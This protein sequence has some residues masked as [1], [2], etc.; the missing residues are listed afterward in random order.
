MIRSGRGRGAVVVLACVLGA[1]AGACGRSDDAE[2]AG[3][4]FS[5]SLAEDERPAVREVL[6]RFRAESG[7]AVAL[8]A[9]TANDLPE[10]LKVE[11]GSGRP[12]I[13]LFA[14][15]NLA[16]RALVDGGLVQALDDVAVPD[17][18]LPAMAPP[19]FGGTRYFLPFRPNVLVTYVNRA[20]LPGGGVPPPRTIADL[21]AVAQAFKARRGAPKVTLAL[22]E[23]APTAITVAELVLGF[24]GDPLVLND[25]GSVAAFELLSGLWRDGLLARESLGGQVR[26]A[27]RPSDQR[28]GVA[29]PE[30]ALYL[31]D[32]GAPGPPRPVRSLRGHG[33]GPFGPPTWSE[34]TFSGS[35]AASPD[36][37]E[38]TPC[39]SPCSSCHARLRSASSRATRGPP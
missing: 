26:H 10:K 15:D 11:V 38:I 3:L 14:Q 12:T 35:P 36:A 8:V 31:G 7:V 22:A 13:D 19:T 2:R 34:G 30:L 33:A 21:R 28:D 1:S 20:R 39:G 23:G 25:A 29:G 6:D 9:V 4:T 16:L 17:G 18:V 24:G 27:G 5:A 37:G 32:P